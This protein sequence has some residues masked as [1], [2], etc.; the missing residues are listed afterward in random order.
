MMST[1]RPRG[2]SQTSNAACARWKDPEN[3][4]QTPRVRILVAPLESM[5]PGGDDEKPNWQNTDKH[6]RTERLR[7]CCRRRARRWKTLHVRLAWELGR[8]SAGA[9]MRCPGPLASG[10]GQRRP[11]LTPC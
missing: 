8:W 6:S 7:G 2:T 10:P 4:C 11:D 1:L 5:N 9:V 3:R